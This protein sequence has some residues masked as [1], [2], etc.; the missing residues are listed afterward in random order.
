MLKTALTLTED[1]LQRMVRYVRARIE[2][3][4]TSRGNGWLADRERFEREWNDDF[5]HR[6]WESAVFAKSNESLNLIGSGV[7]FVRARIME[8]IFGSAPWFSADPRSPSGI[9]PVLAENVTK[10]LR[11]KLGPGQIGFE[12]LSSELITQS[13]KL[14]E[15]VAKVFHKTEEDTYENIASILWDEAADRPVLTED[16]EPIFESQQGNPPAGYCWKERI[17]SERKTRFTGAQAVPLH[18]KEFYCPLNAPSVQE[19]DFVAHMT[20]VRL[21]ELCGHLEVSL[22]PKDDGA[23]SVSATGGGAESYTEQALRRIQRQSTLPKGASAQPS[24]GEGEEGAGATADPEFRVVEA[25]FRFDARDDGR[26]CRVFLMVAYDLD[27][28]VFWDYVANVTPDGRYPFEVVALNKEPHRWYGRSWF[29]KFE[30]F[31]R[32]ID[33]L[34]N[35]I[36]YRNELAANPV[37]FRRK[38]AVLQWQDDQPFEIGPDKVFDLNE[39]YTADDALQSAKIPE[40]DEQTKF[41][42]ETAIANWRSRSG[43]STAAQGTFGSLPAERTATG[44]EQIVTSGSMLLQPLIAEAKRGLEAVL[45]QLVEYQYAFQEEDESFTYKEGDVRVLG[46]LIAAQVRDLEFTVEL[47]LSRAKQAR[48]FDAAKLAVDFFAQFL[49]LPDAFKPVAAPLFTAVYKNLEI[50]HADDYF[51]QAV[52]IAQRGNGGNDPEAAPAVADGP[53][54]TEVDVE[55]IDGE[56]PATAGFGQSQGI[57]PVETEQL[58]TV[59]GL[60]YLP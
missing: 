39:G 53:A 33:K 52:K 48:G 25:Y 19:A 57:P 49:A 23:D 3:I 5:S 13:C 7:D 46:T 17:V 30:K 4:E 44:I 8:D 1:Q 42:L 32:L 12:A 40:L 31:Q 60:D 28:A 11:W 2:S 16:G 27:L 35:Q 20:T 14:G 26:P 47:T 18:Y 43:I 55:A 29:K 50:D 21:S 59:S 45:R 36:I 10:H 6:Q 34:L 38:E 24:P 22:Q 41:L 58:N 15:C 9:D 51:Q 54:P 37:K 56:W